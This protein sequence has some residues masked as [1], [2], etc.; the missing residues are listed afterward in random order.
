MKLFKSFSN[1]YP[2]YIFFRYKFVVADSLI[3]HFNPIR[4]KIDDYLKNPDYLWSVLEAGSDKAAEVA[5]KTLDE[6]KEKVGLGKKLE[7]RIGANL[8]KRNA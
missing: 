4:E 2:Y 6:V 5:E 1:F 8:Q 7:R 3:S